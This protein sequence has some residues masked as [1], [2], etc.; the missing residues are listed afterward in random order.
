VEAHVTA[1]PQGFT[2]VVDLD[3]CFDAVYGLEI[4]S[5][6]V[7]GEGVLRG[8]VAVR[9]E[10]LTEH[11]VLHGGVPAAVAEALASR[12]TALS[13]IPQGFA[14]MGLSNDT[15]ILAAVRDGV[16]DVEAR[17]LSR[18]E[19]AWS[20]TVESRDTAGRA[21]AFSRVTVAVRPMG[22]GA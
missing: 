19:D 15:T 3:A 16:V 2:P 6:D 13:V 10:L 9:G 8:R 12:G 17:L 5:E 20:W 22:P 4:V 11:G 18:G 7:E 14:A 21:C 1:M